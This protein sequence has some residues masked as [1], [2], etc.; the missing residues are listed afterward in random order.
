MGANVFEQVQKLE[1]ERFEMLLAVRQVLTA[2]Q[3]RKIQDMK[4]R[5]QQNRAQRQP[6][7]RPAGQHPQGDQNPGF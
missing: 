1:N 3:W 2:E 7:R 6:G 4:Q 5:I